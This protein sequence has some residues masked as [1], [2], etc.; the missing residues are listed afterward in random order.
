MSNDLSRVAHF[1][2]LSRQTLSVINQ[3]MLCGVVFIG[4][5]IVLS[6][7]GFISPMLASFIHEFGAFFVIFNSAR[8]LKFEGESA[9]AA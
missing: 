4:I 7:A 9:V 3:N 6:S 8:L 5:S 2:T 1:I